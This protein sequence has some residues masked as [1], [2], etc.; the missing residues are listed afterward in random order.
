M[1]LTVEPGVYFIKVLLEPAFDDPVL[2]KF[3]VKEKIQ[4]LMSF[5]GIR[6]E[7]DVAI[8]EDG[9]VNFT[10][11]PREISDIEAVMAGATWDFDTCTVTK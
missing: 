4:P 9:Y 1:Y 2:G 6:L 3:L 8:I 7:D 10:K 11:C 5:G